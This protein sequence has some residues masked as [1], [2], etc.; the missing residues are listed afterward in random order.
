M[1]MFALSEINT[2]KIQTIYCGRSV[3]IWPEY[4]PNESSRICLNGRMSAC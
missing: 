3:S 1:F 2:D 4:G